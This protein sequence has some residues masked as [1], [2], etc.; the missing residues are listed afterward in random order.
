MRLATYQRMPLRRQRIFLSMTRLGGAELDAVGRSCLVRPELFG[1]PMLRLADELLRGPS[2]WTVGERELLAAV[3]SEANSCSFCVGTHSA[4]ADRA[5]PD[6]AFTNWQDGGA[7][8]GVTAAARFVAK[9]TKAPDDVSQADVAAARAAGVT[10]AALAE[11]VYIAFFF[12][13][14]NR[15]ADALGFTHRSE[16]DRLRGAGVLR[17]GGYRLPRFLYG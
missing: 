17:R 11:A 7:G 3:V 5:L 10:D 2:S 1:K 6:P 12:N 13:M 16:R 8:A 15:V 14:I 4:I 9:L